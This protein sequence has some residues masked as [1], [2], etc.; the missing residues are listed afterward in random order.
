MSKKPTAVDDMTAGPAPSPAA[1]AVRPAAEYIGVEPSTLDQWRS[2]ER[3]LGRRLGPRYCQL[4]RK[5]VYKVADL[6]EF[7]DEHQISEVSA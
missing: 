7:L 6:D 5:I 1:L 3:R 4:G 2:K